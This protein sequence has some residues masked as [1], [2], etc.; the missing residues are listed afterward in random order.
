MNDQHLKDPFEAGLEFAEAMGDFLMA[1]IMLI[2]LLLE[3][4]NLKEEEKRKQQIRENLQKIKLALEQDRSH[5]DLMQMYTLQ[6]LEVA[7]LLQ[8]R[9][10]YNNQPALDF[11]SKLFAHRNMKQDQINAS[12]HR[13][14]RR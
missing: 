3:S 8:K 13:R 9:R 4:H 6:L 7:D 5:Q 1:L 12:L 14:L 10:Q 2:E 11:S